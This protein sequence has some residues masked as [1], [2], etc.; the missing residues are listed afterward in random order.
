MTRLLCLLLSGLVV[1]LGAVLPFADHPAQAFPPAGTNVLAVSAAVD[2]TSRLGDESLVLTGWAE[3]ARSEPRLEGGVGVADIEIVALDLRGASQLG[4]IT[5]GIREAA[6]SVGEIRSLQPGQDFPASSFFALRMDVIV[7]ASP[8][9]SLVLHN[10]EP[11]HLRPRA[12]GLEVP[13]DAWPPL[14]AVY[15]LDPIFGFDNDGDGLIDEDTA[16]EDGD[17][18]IDEDRPGID[19][20]TPGTG[21]EC[22]SDAD[23]DGLEGEDP[24]ADLCTLEL[25]DADGDGLI[26]E[27]PS[28]IPLLNPGNTH[29]KA[30]FCVRALALEIAP[31]LPSFSAARGGPS[32]LHPAD[33]LALTPAAVAP[34]QPVAVSG[35]DDFSNAWNIPT[36]PFIGEQNTETATLESLN[37]GFLSPKASAPDAGAGDGDGFEV[38]PENAF[39][40]DG[41]FAEDVDSGT[42]ALGICASA[43]PQGKDRHVFRDFNVD[44]PS[45]SRVRGIEVRLDAAVDAITG[46]PS[47]MCVHLSDDGGSTWSG[48]P[49]FTNTLSTVETTHILG[50]PTDNWFTLW[51]PDGL[52]N[53]NFRVRVT[54]VASDNE[55]D[56]RLDW[57]AARI[58][59][60]IEPVSAGCGR[61]ANTTWYS[62]TP[63]VSHVVTFDTVGSNFDTVLAAFTGDDV[64][65]LSLVVCN[66]DFASA[67]GPSS[68][69]FQAAPGVTYYIQAGGFAGDSG[70]VVFNASFPTRQSPF[71]R[72]PCASLGLSPDGCDDGADGDQDDIDAISFGSDLPP[73]GPLGVEFSV[74]PGARGAPGTAVDEQYNC[75]PASPGL[76]PEAEPDEF[77]SE[78][79]GTNVHLL[80]GNGPIGSCA[81]AFPLGFV[82]G[83]TVRDDLDAL[84]A[85]GVSAIDPDDD[86][87]P[88]NTVYFSLDAA[89]PSLAALGASPAD[90][91]LTQGGATPQLYASAAALGLQ[92]GDDLDALCLRESGDGSFGAGDT[93]YFSLAPG[94][95]TLAALGAA[96]GDL[97]APGPTVAREHPSLGLVTGDDV[98][99]LTCSAVVV[100]VKEPGGDVDCSGET[101]SIDAALILQ[102]DAGL[103]ASLACDSHGDVNRDGVTNSVDATLV[104]Q[105]VAGFIDRL[106]FP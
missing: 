22:G 81:V 36:A 69:S 6:P 66:D 25:C 55:R 106:P 48:F 42:D 82:E 46:A 10:E 44:T 34:P 43:D 38:A 39:A 71:V 3:L 63:T 96:P 24:P 76:S 92:A 28:C 13:I 19:P 9:G 16:D 98:N 1:A 17:G 87:V 78:L 49:P 26:D 31:A 32:P 54:N 12:A 100:E 41:A 94:S 21:A 75:P 67:G 95:P 56:F 58:T 68:I 14:G 62:Y 88:D 40:D 70:D 50:S 4:V 37:T 52:T 18:L 20:D 72:I 79:D 60:D 91:L 97:F 53:E 74:G 30:G 90:V 51:R 23:C 105:F 83:A 5:V 85:N 102:L 27:D 84:D 47:F 77:G 89:S 73:N 59:E 61:P 15:E 104:L 103:L 11:L 57:V 99:A 8:L 65:E 7:P 101:E 86:G 45:L 2:V 29:L 80:D 64:Y 35:N 93:L 33:I